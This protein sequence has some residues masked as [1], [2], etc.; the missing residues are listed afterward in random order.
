MKSALVV[1]SGTFGSY[2]GSFSA[3]ADRRDNRRIRGKCI[4]LHH[5]W[6]IRLTWLHLLNWTSGSHY[7]GVINKNF[8]TATLLF[9]F[10]GT[11][12]L[13]S[14]KRKSVSLHC[15]LTRTHLTHKTEMLYIIWSACATKHLNA[16]DCSGWHRQVS[17]SQLPLIFLWG[18]SLHQRFFRGCHLSTVIYYSQHTAD[19]RGVAMCAMSAQHW[20]MGFLLPGTVKV[21]T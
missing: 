5:E 11:V 9:T 7:P 19:H 2:G 18:L 8:S 1:G 4:K 12:L 14:W 15:N 6:I 20:F 17:S 21:S 16:Q 10:G 3:V 13:S